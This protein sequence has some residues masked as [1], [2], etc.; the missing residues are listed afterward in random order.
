MK[1]FYSPNSPYARKCL[2]AAYELGLRERIETVAANA[3]PTKRDPAIAANNPLSK[4]PTLIA[5][6][7][8]VL[9]DSPVI[10]EYLDSLGGGRLIPRDGPARWNVL[11]EQALADGV[12]DAALLARY[13]T[14]L[15]PEPLR[16]S[17]WTS[18]QLEKVV[19]GLDEFER[20]AAHFADRVDLGTI[21]F[22]C[23]LGYIDFRWSSLDW[24]KSRP[25]AAAW[26]ERFAARD[27]MVK[28]RPPG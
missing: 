20:R 1:L 4:V 12:L 9:Y 25:A 11:V 14:A 22:A 8:T 15:R 17:D 5:D 26:Y 10:A 16:W 3:M 21:A 24:R 2:V 7:G 18:G 28:T 6:D 13:E 23:A 19:G 27:S